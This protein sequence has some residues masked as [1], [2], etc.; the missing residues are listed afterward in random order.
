MITPIAIHLIADMS[1]CQALEGFNNAENKHMEF[2]RRPN[3]AMSPDSCV[4]EDVQSKGG[5]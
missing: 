4:S 3:G 2:K 1:A 5:F